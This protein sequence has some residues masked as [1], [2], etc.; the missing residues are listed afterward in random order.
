MVRSDGGGEFSKGAFGV[1]CT[2]GKIK[3]E[4]TT[5]DSP[6]Y[7]GVAERQIVIIEAAGLAARI[8]AAVKY[9][10]E[11]FPRGESLWASKLIGLGSR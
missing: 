7:N 3:Q 1:L 4:F 11:V 10:N 8:Q 5:V 6:Q 9:P 2:T